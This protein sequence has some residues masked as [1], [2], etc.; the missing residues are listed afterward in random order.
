MNLVRK[1][2]FEISKRYIVNCGKVFRNEDAFVH[3][4]IKAFT[5][6]YVKFKYICCIIDKLT[7]MV[8]KCFVCSGQT[9][10]YIFDICGLPSKYTGLTKNGVGIMCFNEP[11][12]SK[13]LNK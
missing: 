3:C 11:T 1:K 13:N 7:F 8:E 9:N 5:E 4:S 10:D 6:F 2:P 12:L